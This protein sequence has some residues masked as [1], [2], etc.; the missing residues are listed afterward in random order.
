VRVLIPFNI[1]T[2]QIT[3]PLSQINREGGINLNSETQ[4]FIV[5]IISFFTMTKYLIHDK[6]EVIPFPRNKITFERVKAPRLSDRKRVLIDLILTRLRSLKRG[7]FHA[8]QM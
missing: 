4:V 6:L 7:D 2:P 3:S 1:H 8:A 5:L